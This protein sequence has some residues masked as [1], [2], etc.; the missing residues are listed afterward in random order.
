M[1]VSGPE[2]ACEGL[3]LTLVFPALDQGKCWKILD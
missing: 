1:S 2:G 3:S